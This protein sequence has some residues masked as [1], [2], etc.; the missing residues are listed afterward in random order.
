[1]GLQSEV[2][3]GQPG[4]TGVHCDAG[5]AWSGS[6]RIRSTEPV[7]HNHWIAD[8]RVCDRVESNP[9]DNLLGSPLETIKAYVGWWRPP[10]RVRSAAIVLYRHRHGLCASRV[11]GGDGGNRISHLI[12]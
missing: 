3:R 2:F 6:G 12:T 8:E 4:R 1:M 5:C 10:E 11:G 7:L 9:I